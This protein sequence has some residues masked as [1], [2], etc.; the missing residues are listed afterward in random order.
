MYVAK[1]L[2][3]LLL[4]VQRRAL[5]ALLTHRNSADMQKGTAQCASVYGEST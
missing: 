1:S 5:P 2:A 3:T 4:L